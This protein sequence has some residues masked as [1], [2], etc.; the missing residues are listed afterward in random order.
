MEYYRLDKSISVVNIIVVD[1]SIQW[2]DIVSTPLIIV[3]FYQFGNILG[4]HQ[5]FWVWHTSS[6]DS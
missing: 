4:E 3:I 2:Y 5:T 6:M 1:T